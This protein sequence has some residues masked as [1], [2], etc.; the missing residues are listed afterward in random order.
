M[1]IKGNTVCFPNPQ[2]NWDQED[3]ALADYLQNKPESLDG[4]AVTS[5]TGSRE[6]QTITLT[7]GLENGGQDV[8]TMTLGD[9]DCPTNVNVNGVDIPIELEGF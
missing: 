4:P 9:D 7:L 3:S 2:T 1:R 5:V 8:L 6:G